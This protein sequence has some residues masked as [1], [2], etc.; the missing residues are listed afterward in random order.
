MIKEFTL[1]TH[2]HYQL[3][4]IT[5]RI[6]DIITKSKVKDGLCLIFTPGSTAAIILTEN[7]SGLKHDWLKFL[8]KIVE[9]KK[10]SAEGG[11]ASGWEHD[12]IDDNA[13]SHLLSG[14]LGQGKTLPIESGR[15]L[16]GTWQQIFFVELD[17]PRS[18]RRVIVKITFSPD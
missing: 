9:G 3:I 8:K 13:D 15:L 10:N 17:G 7:E 2:E 11:T 12:R 1:S 6:E 14:L 4:D 18:T 5:D 16:R